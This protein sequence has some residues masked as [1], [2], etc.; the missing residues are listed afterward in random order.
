MKE[1][2]T[3]SQTELDQIQKELQNTT[4]GA[5]E[6]SQATVQQSVNQSK[7]E[8]DKG[9]SEVKTLF[10]WGAVVITIIGIFKVITILVL[11]K[12][13]KKSKK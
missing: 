13:F 1:N 8:L 9:I 2:R 6:K 12:I 11:K 3:L 4:Q 5:K 7:A 10:L